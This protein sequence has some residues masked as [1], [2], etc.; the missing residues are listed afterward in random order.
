MLNPKNAIISIVNMFFCC[1]LAYPLLA[2]DLRPEKLRIY[3]VADGLAN[4]YISCIDQDKE[5]NLW[6]G[7]LNGAS[8]FDGNS[9]AN[10]GSA[11]GFSNKRVW[12]IL[13]DSKGFIWFGTDGDGL[14]RFDGKN[15]LQFKENAVPGD[16]FTEGFLYED[17]RG[18]IWGGSVYLKLF[19]YYNGR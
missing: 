8:K 5:G 12:A 13:C 17:T 19:K 18:N 10:Y 15:W 4:D 2:Q 3:T 14:F 1:A 6:I 7:H 11:D 16:D 9:F